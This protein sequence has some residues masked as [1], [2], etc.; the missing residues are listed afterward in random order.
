MKKNVEGTKASQGA[1]TMESRYINP[2]TDFGFKKLFGEEGN[3]NLLVSF[4][5]DLLPIQKKIVQISFKKNQQIGDDSYSRSAVYD[6]FCEDES[7][8]QFIVEMQNARQTYF[9]DRAVFYSTFPIRDQAQ[10]GTWNFK[11]QDVY[12]VG[13]LGFNLDDAP[14][15]DE[16]VIEEYIHTVNLKDQN[17]K[18]FYHI[19]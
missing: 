18:L 1:E 9:R 10:K 11:L 15:E 19:S 5:N 17:N 8:N 3:K 6:I 2:F 12:C 13:L 4:L 7:G 16:A 14:T